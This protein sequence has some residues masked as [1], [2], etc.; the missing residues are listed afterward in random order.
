MLLL[1]LFLQQ[2]SFFVQQQKYFWR[3]Y[4]LLLLMSEWSQIFDRDPERSVEQTNWLVQSEDQWL[5]AVMWDH[6]RRVICKQHFIKATTLLIDG[7]LKAKLPIWT[8]RKKRQFSFEGK[9][10]LIVG[11]RQQHEID[12]NNT[13]EVVAMTMTL[14]YFEG[15]EPLFLPW[16]AHPES[17]ILYHSLSSGSESQ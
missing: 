10:Q 9:R 12:E 16:Q 2:K 15:I 13:I 4:W 7:F 8:C 11:K 1:N 14:C 3:I 17:H 5:A 6:V